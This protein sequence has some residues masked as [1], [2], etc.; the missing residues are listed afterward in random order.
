MVGGSVELS[1]WLRLSYNTVLVLYYTRVH[2]HRTCSVLGIVLL[3]V[4]AVQILSGVLLSFSLNCDP[5]NV[6]MSRSEDDMDDLYT[7][8]FFWIHERGVDYIF[9]FI[10]AH[11][12]RKFYLHSFTQ[13]Q[14]GAWKTGSLLFLLLH[15]VTFFGLVLCCTHLSEVTLTIA[16]NIAAS[17]TAKHGKI[18]WWV[19][20]AQELNY[21]TMLRL[22]YGH[23][24]SAFILFALAVMHA[25]EMHLDWKDTGFNESQQ[26]G[27]SW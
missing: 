13:V 11:M 18:Y 27:L 8:D 24:V 17:L 22:M 23:Y 1:A 7:D 5:M 25:L 10:F 2:Q 14:E 16:A 20:P 3:V 19:F 15:V 4:F 12:L 21:D 6:P 26:L 9:I